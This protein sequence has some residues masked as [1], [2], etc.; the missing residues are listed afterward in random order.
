[1]RVPGRALL[2][3]SQQTKGVGS[4]RGHLRR[5]VV[6]VGVLVGTAVFGTSLTGSSAFAARPDR[7]RAASGI[8]PIVE[9]TVQ[10]GGANHSVFGYR[11]TGAKSTISVGDRNQFTPGTPDRGQPTTFESGTH[12]NV[13]TVTESASLTW[14]LEG[15]RVRAPG[16]LCQTD[17][18]ASSIAAWGPIGALMIVTLLLGSLLYYRN[19]RIRVR[20]R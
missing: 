9:C 14:T 10:R 2:R 17:S 3:A 4:M 6:T 7:T 1:M 8:T 13:F 12:I 19:R 16:I 11:N 18:V 15:Q 5:V 20:D